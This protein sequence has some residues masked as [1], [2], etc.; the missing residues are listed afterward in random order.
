MKKI[1]VF[2][3]AAVGLLLLSSCCISSG[4][5]TGSD[6]SE[7]LGF[8]SDSS[9]WRSL[10]QVIGVDV[11]SSSTSDL[12]EQLVTQ[13][14]AQCPRERSFSVL[15]CPDKGSVNVDCASDFGI[16]CENLQFGDALSILEGLCGISIYVLAESRRILV[17]PGGGTTTVVLHLQS[18]L[19]T[20]STEG[21]IG[22]FV[23][24]SEW[25]ESRVRHHPV[26]DCAF[27][28]K[29]M[30]GDGGYLLVLTRS[31]SWFVEVL[32]SAV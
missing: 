16:E 18:A 12:V 30:D 15:F 3:A 25:F 28:L 9:I 26:H 2:V 29:G 21:R 27:L 23:D 20:P 5:G 1:G 11:E 13:Y 4:R 8:T 19:V 32:V 24:V 14:N 6:R 31:D 10:S 7:C 17:C 22:D